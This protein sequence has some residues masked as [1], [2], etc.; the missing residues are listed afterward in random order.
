MKIERALR[1]TWPEGAATLVG[2][3]FVG[4]PALRAIARP[5]LVVLPALVLVAGILVGW[6]FARGRL[7]V[8]LVALAITSIVLERLRAPYA[9]PVLMLASI[10]IPANFALLGFLPEAPPL[11]RG[12]QWWWATLA[13][14][15]LIVAALCGAAPLPVAAALSLPLFPVELGGWTALPQLAFL[16]AAI[17]IG[18]LGYRLLHQ[19]VRASRG[20]M[21]ATLGAAVAFGTQVPTNRSLYFTVAGLAILVAMVE[22]SYSLAFH[23]ELTS[24]PS[25]R[26]FNQ[27]LAGLSGTYVIAMVDVDHFKHFNDQYGHDVGDQVLR[28]VAGRLAHVGDVGRGYRYGG[29]EF[30]VVFPDSRLRDTE[31]DLEALRIAIEMATFTFRGDDRP[32][33]TPQTPRRG[34]PARRRDLNVTVSIGAAQAAETPE[35]TVEAADKALY[36]AKDTGRNRVVAG[37]GR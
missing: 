34:R 12:A 9:R 17:A 31:E 29:E 32:K 15:I 20:L 35:M 11:S 1:L 37:A 2:L 14:E 13:A 5:L 10:L 26:S 24:L 33:D 21:W 22:A 4:W 19:P 3:L 6:R 18:L 16:S 23:D 36:K 30:A 28:M 8:A 7:F 25:R 27:A